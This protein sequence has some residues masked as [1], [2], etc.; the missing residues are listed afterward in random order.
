MLCYHRVGNRDQALRQ[1]QKCST[2]LKREL[3]A[4]PS[5]KTLELYKKIK[6]DIPLFS[7]K[8]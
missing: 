7:Y 4:K 6:A 2:I 3:E 1:F 8:E 5:S